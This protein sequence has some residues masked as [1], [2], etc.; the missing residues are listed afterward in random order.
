[1]E[2]CAVTN[3]GFAAFV[4][5]TGYVTDAERLGWPYVFAGFLPGAP[6]RD[7]PRPEETPW[8]CAVAGAVWNRPE[9]PGSTLAGR[10]GH[11]AVHVSLHDAA[12]YAA[13][14]GKRL[15]TEA[16]WEYAARG[17]LEQKRHPWGDEFDPGGAYRSHGLPLRPRSRTR[18]SP[19]APGRP[20]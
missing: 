2:V 5:G 3:D 15:P 17:D 14:A 9:G 1:M 20:P 10:G 11:P 12:A 19:P 16:E 7:A 4:A 18:S 6:R 8:W 13:R